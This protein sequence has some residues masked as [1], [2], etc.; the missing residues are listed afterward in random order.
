MKRD[1]ESLKADIS[2]PAKAAWQIGDDAWHLVDDA[3]F[4][5]TMPDL[6]SAD[7]R[8]AI[9]EIFDAFYEFDDAATRNDEAAQRATF[10]RFEAAIV[11]LSK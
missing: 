6:W 9:E 11:Q 7:D 8:K 10:S 1:F 3:A 4:A 2:E 5:A